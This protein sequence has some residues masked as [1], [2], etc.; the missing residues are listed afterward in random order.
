VLIFSPGFGTGPAVRNAMDG[1][2]SSSA[3][4][5]C[6]QHETV[7]RIHSPAALAGRRFF[8]CDAQRGDE[9]KRLMYKQP[10]GNR[11]D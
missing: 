9:G 3:E 2:S 8:L 6:E 4:R 1:I 5:V 7:V 10:I 11:E